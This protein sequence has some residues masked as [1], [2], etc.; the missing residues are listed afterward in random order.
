MKEGFDMVK[1]TFFYDESEHS[2]KISY[3]T[4][5]DKNFE[6]NFVVAIV[7]CQTDSLEEL[8]SKYIELERAYK[9]F[10]SV[11]E[12]KN[13]IIKVKK[14]KYGL[15]S[16]K[17]NDLNLITEVFSFI[18]DNDFKVYISV[19]NK[20]EFIVNQ[21]LKEYKND[22]FIDADLF[23][24]I[25]T[26]ILNVYF[27]QNVIQVIYLD[28]NKFKTELKNFC[29]MLLNN[30]KNLPHKELENETINQ[31]LII[32]NET[33]HDFD[34]NWDYSFAFSG[35]KN[36][37]IENKYEVTSL[38]ID[39]EGNGSTYFAAIEEGFIKTVEAD[40]ASNFG[41]RIADFV[42][43]TISRFIIN[44]AKQTRYTSIDDAKNIKL[45]D[46]QWFNLSK[47]MFECYKTLKNAI[48]GTHRSFYKFTN[49]LYTDDFLCFISLLNYI[50]KFDDFQSFIKDKTINHSLELNNLALKNL[51]EKFDSMRSKLKLQPVNAGNKEFYINGKGAIC[52]FDYNR[53][54][55]LLIKNG[56]TKYH[57]LSV[58]LFG[59][60]EKACVTIRTESGPV[61]YLLPDQLLPWAFDMVALANAGRDLFPTDVIFTFVKGK[62]YVDLD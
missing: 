27:P 24:Y 33:S 39:Q 10:Y 45:L 46:E 50:D 34:I 60:F 11:D 26:K 16:F 22:L 2:R 17:K 6:P 59:K 54:K 12:L 53:H 25:V 49:S 41:I 36:F 43:G 56:S 5:R 3:D 57:V 18:N 28:S 51:Y 30:N 48:V 31:L 37:I 38:Y 7:G 40:S 8:E 32:L 20:I 52:Y 47:D 35:F 9:K 19:N 13:N 14:Y 23:R 55:Y 42:A 1:H 15:N 4:V 58:G 44:I 29:L 21:L 61:L 62:Y